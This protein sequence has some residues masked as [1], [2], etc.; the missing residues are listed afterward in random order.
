MT[1][2]V[3][4]KTSLADSRVI[5]LIKTE[6]FGDKLHPHPQND[7]KWHHPDCGDGSL[8]NVGSGCLAE[9]N[10]SSLSNLSVCLSL[11]IGA[12]PTGRIFIKTDN[13]DFMKIG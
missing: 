3:D 1:K 9:K 12:A 10:F 8:R 6:R 2:E 5:L 13:G 11:R 7:T 4:K